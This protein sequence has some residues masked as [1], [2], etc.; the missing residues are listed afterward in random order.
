VFSP[1]GGQHHAKPGHAS[2][3]CFLNEPALSIGTLKNQGF[4]RIFYLDFD[5]HHGDGVEAAFADDDTV[6]TLSIHEAGRWPMDRDGGDGGPGTLTGGMARASLNLPVPKGLNDTEYA[7]LVDTVVLPMMER[8]RPDAVYLQCGTDAL[9][10]DPQSKLALSNTALWKG[11]AAVRDAAPRL[12]VTGGGGYN[13]YAVARAWAGVWAVLG[14]FDIPERLPAAAEAVLRSVAWN[15]RLGRAPKEDW[16][17]RLEDE[18]N[19]GDVRGDVR[20]LVE[21]A[22]SAAC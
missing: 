13:P 2:G 3:F 9:S 5:A 16:L 19:A 18:P 4:E 10:D 12:M 21:A 11:V 17:T 14:G 15:H 1:A 22:L 20:D 6:F 7:Y 8:F